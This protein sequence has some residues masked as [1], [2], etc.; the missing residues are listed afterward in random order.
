MA[1]F[2]PDLTAPAPLSSLTELHS[3]PSTP[4]C[5]CLRTFSL[6]CWFPASPRLPGTISSSLKTHGSPPRKAVLRGHGSRPLVLSGLRSCVLNWQQPEC[7][8]SVFVPSLSRACLTD[9][10]GDPVSALSIPKE[11]DAIIS[12][13]APEG[14]ALSLGVREEWEKHFIWS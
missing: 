2:Q 6:L 14:Q 5:F 1:V 3:D 7:G 10:P 13:K 8:S 9:R 12:V 4:L 11:G